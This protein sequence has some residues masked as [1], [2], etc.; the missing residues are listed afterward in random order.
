MRRLHDAVPS[1]IRAGVASGVG[2]LHLAMSCDRSRMSVPRT[3][4]GR[5]GIRSPTSEVLPADEPE[6]L[7]VAY[8][9]FLL[10][11]L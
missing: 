5:E 9:Y 10:T 3:T 6:V 8:A 4:P 2:T 11:A 1:T 7:E